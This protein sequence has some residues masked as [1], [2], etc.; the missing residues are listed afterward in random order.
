VLVKHTGV[1]TLVCGMGQCTTEPN[2]IVLRSQCNTTLQCKLSTT[3]KIPALHFSQCLVEQ[4]LQFGL[5]I[6][7]CLAEICISKDG[8]KLASIV[9]NQQDVAPEGVEPLKIC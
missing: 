2:I 7:G 5:E 9:A 3:Y 1:S 6:V 4:E 8:C